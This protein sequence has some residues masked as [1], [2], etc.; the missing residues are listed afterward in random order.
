MNSPRFRP[1]LYLTGTVLFWG[2]SF[3]A[4]KSAMGSFSPMT[5]MWL[6][7]IVASLVFL[8]FWRRV[9]RPEYRP[10]DWKLLGLSVLFIPCLYYLLEGF[11]VHF[12]TSSQAGVVSAIMPLMVAA[13]AWLLLRERL[14]WQGAVG[15][16]VS[17]VG[18][19]IL[20][21]A[22]A[23]QESAPAPV[24][25]NILELAAM[26][27]AAGSTL[28]VKHLSSRYDPWFLTGL[29]A[30]VGAVFFA[31]L[32]LA[33]GA[34]GLASAD[35]MAWV[36]V[37]YLGTFASLGAFGLYNSALRLMPANR[38]AL[39]INM[40]PAVAMLTGWIMLGESLTLLQVG[41]CGLI[42]GAVVF[43]EVSG[44]VAPVEAP[45]P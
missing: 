21:L 42:L 23:S 33:S 41:A 31:P 11:A 19:G 28:V 32:A 10:G 30:A 14:S 25:G 17:I 35:P 7:M 40:I 13:G 18:V 43:A 9:P 5:V 20:S 16:A 39:A 8:P 24:L 44:H 36:A 1:L 27:A 2:T 45:V 29:Q 12:T 15:I 38:A 34:L 6:R 26:V 22:G 37:V 3:A 4:I